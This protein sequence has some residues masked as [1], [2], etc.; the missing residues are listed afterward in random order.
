LQPAL[1][2]DK[3]QDLTGAY[4]LN[5]EEIEIVWQKKTAK[6]VGEVPPAIGVGA[7]EKQN[8]RPP[9]VLTR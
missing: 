6:V 8:P 5:G 2:R 7:E 1:R 4:R 3:R 9:D